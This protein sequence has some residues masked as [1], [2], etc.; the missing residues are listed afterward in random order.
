METNLAPVPFVVWSRTDIMLPIVRVMAWSC[1]GSLRDHDPGMLP[2]QS[3][4][5]AP[6]IN[7]QKQ[8]SVTMTWVSGLRA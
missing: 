4:A 7:L 8:R 1:L 5:A 6:A 3:K 2:K